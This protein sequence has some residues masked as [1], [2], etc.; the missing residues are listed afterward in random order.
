MAYT[1]NAAYSSFDEN[2]KGTLEPGKFADFV[3]LSE[4][5]F[6][7]EPNKIKDVHVLQTYIGGNKVF[8]ELCCY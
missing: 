4:D 7:I 8:G 5:L 6:S 3:I 2:L 1:K